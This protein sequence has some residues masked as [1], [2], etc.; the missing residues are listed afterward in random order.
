VDQDKLNCR[1]MACLSSSWRSAERLLEWAA[2][3]RRATARR[4]PKA[5]R[6]EARGAATRS[7]EGAAG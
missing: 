4:S 5:M 2:S 7:R 6:G 1:P 3:L